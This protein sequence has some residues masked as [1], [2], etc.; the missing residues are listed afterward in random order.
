MPYISHLGPL[1]YRLLLAS[2]VSLLVAAI[3]VAKAMGILRGN[4]FPGFFVAM[5]IGFSA[6]GIASLA[7]GLKIHR[8]SPERND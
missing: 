2:A 5:A 4:G 6:F 3:A 8:D 1:C 7:Y